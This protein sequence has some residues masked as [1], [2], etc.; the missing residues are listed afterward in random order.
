ML[1]D[2]ANRLRSLNPWHF[3]W[4]SVLLS[5][6]FTA[7]INSVQ[8]FL[9]WGFISRELLIIGAIDS[10]FVPLIV[11]PMIIYFLEKTKE[12][13]KSNEQLIKENTRR[14]QVEEE[15]RA[16]KT[17]T[18]N[19]LNALQEIFFVFDVNGRFLW[20]VLTTSL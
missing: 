1:K 13:T 12:L 5:E 4:I 19:A 10:L 9:R 7:A 17:F 14:R 18:Q 15:L 16:E 11:A 3:L 6:I 2:Y 8:S 20:C